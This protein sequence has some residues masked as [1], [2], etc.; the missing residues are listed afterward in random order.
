MKKII[1]PLARAYEYILEENEKS[2]TRSKNLALADINEAL[3]EIEKFKEE[4]LT[5]EKSL[6]VAQQ[7]LHFHPGN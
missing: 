7:A 2:E 1:E 4:L 5:I 3:H 6:E